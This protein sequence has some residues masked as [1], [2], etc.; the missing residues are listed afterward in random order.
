MFQI[1]LDRLNNIS[2][3][4]F[5]SANLSDLYDIIHMLLDGLILIKGIK[6]KGDG[7]HFEMIKEGKNLNFYSSKEEFLIQQIRDIRNR[8]KYE[9]FNVDFE[10]ILRNKKEILKIIQKLKNL[11][12]FI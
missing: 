12:N 10:Y 6:F 2:F 9:G 11:Y 5:P 3:K 1:L 4:K 8:Y 7:A